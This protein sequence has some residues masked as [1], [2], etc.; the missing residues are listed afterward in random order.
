MAHDTGDIVL[1]QFNNTGSAVLAQ[2]ISSTGVLNLVPIA[3]NTDLLPGAGR[4]S[5]AVDAD[6]DFVV[7]WDGA[8]APGVATTPI[9]ARVFNADGTAESDPITVS[10]R[11]ALPV[12]VTADSTLKQFEVAWGDLAGAQPQPE[13]RI[14][15]VPEIPPPVIIIP[16]PHG[17]PEVPGVPV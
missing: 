12:D 7:A 8:V 17:M 13:G 3:V 10:Q 2:Q 4:T 16:K 11:N 1:T 6:G 5:V 9:L 14:F 15:K